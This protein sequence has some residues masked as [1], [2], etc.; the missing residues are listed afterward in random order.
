MAE[1]VLPFV[2]GLDLTRNDF[3]VTGRS[4][5]PQFCIL[6]LN[7]AQHFSFQ[8]LDF[9]KRVADMPN[10]RWLKLNKTGLESLPDEL[11]HLMKLVKKIANCVFFKLFSYM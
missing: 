3:K 6:I 5:F 1:G 8:K 4:F 11:S 7:R 10:L 9:P 2:R